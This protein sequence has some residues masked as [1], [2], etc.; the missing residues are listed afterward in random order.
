MGGH[1]SNG[2]WDV[3]VVGAGPAGCVIASRLSED[4]DRQVLLLEAGPD[5]GLEPAAWPSELRDPD[6]VPGAS[7]PWGYAD[8]GRIG[9]EPLALPRARIVGGCST[10]NACSWVPWLGH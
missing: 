2:P 5:Y 8:R 7:H 10:N 4:P 9:A 1:G 3:V 6:A